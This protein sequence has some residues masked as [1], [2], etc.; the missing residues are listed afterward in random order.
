MVGGVDEEGGS[1]KGGT[2]ENTRA[3]LSEEWLQIC[4]ALRKSLKAG[5]LELAPAVAEIVR[6]ELVLAGGAT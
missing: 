4:P 3:K 1:T 6:P 2:H 5:S